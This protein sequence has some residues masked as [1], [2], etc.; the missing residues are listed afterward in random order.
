MWVK[1]WTL[2]RTAIKGGNQRPGPGPSPDQNLHSQHGRTR[3]PRK[4]IEEAI[5]LL[6]VTLQ[7][8]QRERV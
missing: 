7:G 2:V 6:V 8:R 1:I 4:P 3:V 5:V